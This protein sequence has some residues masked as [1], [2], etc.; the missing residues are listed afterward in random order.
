MCTVSECCFWRSFAF[1]DERRLSTLAEDDPD[2]I[3][4]MNKPQRFVMVAIW[5][6]Q[7]DLSLR[8]TM[9][10]VIQMLEGV[11]EVPFPPCPWPFNITS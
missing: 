10:K 11:L 9:R 5:C 2:A 3:S 7:E 6:I 1:E 8:P 4:D